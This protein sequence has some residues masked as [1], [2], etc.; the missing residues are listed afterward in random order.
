MKKSQT[1][2][3]I[4]GLKIIEE[5]GILKCCEL[6]FDPDN[7]LVV[8]KGAVGSGKTTLQKSLQIGTAGSKALEDNELY[9]KINQETQLLDGEQKIFIGCKTGKSSNLEYIIYT[10]DEQGKIIKNP[11]ID[12][13]KATPASYLNNLQTALTWRMN[14]LTSEDKIVQ[15]KLLLELYKKELAMAGVIFD[16]GS[17]KYVDSILYN[18]EKAINLRTQLDFERKK[19]GG[20]LNQLEPLGIYPLEDPDTIPAF[21]NIQE[22]ESQKN[23]LQYQIDN[24]I[25]TRKTK[26]ELIKNKADAIV[27]D[28][29]KEN[30]KLLAINTEEQKN[31][32]RK[33]AELDKVKEK[34]EAIRLNINELNKLGYIN[35]YELLIKRFNNELIDIEVIEPKFKKTIQF[36]EKQQIISEAADFE[37]D[38]IKNLLISLS[39]KR[40]EYVNLLNTPADD[41]FAQENELQLVLNNIFLAKENNK[42]CEMVDAFL[43][44]HDADAEVVRLR[45]DYI[46]MLGSIDTG[47]QGLKICVEED[48]S[49]N[50]NIYLTYNGL[51]DP[52]YFNNLDL[53]DRKISSYSG[54][55]KPLICLLLQNYL[56]DTKPKA[57]RYLWIDNVPID[58][59]TKK[60]LE[61]MSNELDLTIIVN[62][63]G[64]FDQKELRDG[65]ILIEDGH[66]L[67]KNQ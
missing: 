52:K 50:T 13:V 62:I 49:S 31:V 21:Q 26:L 16:K 33:N 43:K 47:V 24:I 7:K 28:I 64:D 53:Q 66:L 37:E 22:L 29:V 14:E 10:K 4:I 44:W 51:Y 41:T 60:L 1:S 45:N 57:L 6:A 20:F 58:N 67:F 3:K 17:E 63:T 9:G 25:E 39:E 2:V 30:N 48:E 40:K 36:N 15:K 65:E 5:L 55:Q 32:D 54:T 42:K 46:R 11:V 12:G 27:N 61:K 19:V 59:K 18:I 23:K 35:D 34:I 38:I 8:V 56:L